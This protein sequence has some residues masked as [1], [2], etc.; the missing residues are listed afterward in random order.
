MIYTDT[1]SEPTAKA[2]ALV[3]VLDLLY[4]T[5]L[6]AASQSHRVTVL[7]YVAWFSRLSSTVVPEGPKVLVAGTCCLLLVPNHRRIKRS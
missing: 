3:C 6:D 2:S 5:L 1:A 7:K 4:S